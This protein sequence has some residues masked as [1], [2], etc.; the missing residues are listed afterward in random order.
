MVDDIND[1]KRKCKPICSSPKEIGRHPRRSTTS[2]MA[3]PLHWTPM[4]I[5]DLPVCMRR[6]NLPQTL[7]MC[8]SSSHAFQLKVLSRFNGMRSALNSSASSS[9]ILATSNIHAHGL[10]VQYSIHLNLRVETVSP[11]QQTNTR[12][13]G[14]ALNTP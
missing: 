2:K 12:F 6:R 4:I 10:Q 3:A 9:V 11:S 5:N 13:C 1:T 14:E 7:A 8:N